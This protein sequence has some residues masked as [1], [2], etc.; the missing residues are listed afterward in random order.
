MTDPPPPGGWPDPTW[1]GP[2]SSPPVDPTLVAGPPVPTQPGPPPMPGY[3]LPGY[4]PPGY[5]PPYPGYGYPTPP[6]TNGMAIAAFVLAL[7]G[8]TSCLTAPVGAILGHV[9]RK[10][11]RVSGE[12]GDGMAK[13]AIIIG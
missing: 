10:Q 12:G 9:A 1:S 5:P 11:I 3:A 7:V 6:K 2:Q 13:A 8:I 4:P